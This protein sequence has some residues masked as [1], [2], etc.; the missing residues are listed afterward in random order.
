M[1][2][3]RYE[4]YE[5]AKGAPWELV[6]SEEDIQEYLDKE[7]GLI[8]G[9]GFTVT[10]EE[11]PPYYK[12]A[13]ANLSRREGPDILRHEL[14]HVVTHKPREYLLLGDFKA[15]YWG[16]KKVP[17]GEEDIRYLTL[18]RRRYSRRPAGEDEERY[19]DR[20]EFVVALEKEA[21]REVGEPLYPPIGYPKWVREE[22]WEEAY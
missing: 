14:G 7:G 9:L 17:S 16:L 21:A 22:L 15:I 3:T 20:V 10:P 18:L 13:Y 8:S 19:R 11:G 2:P 4:T 12:F 5:E 1:K 6:T